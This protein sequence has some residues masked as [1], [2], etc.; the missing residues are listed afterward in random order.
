[1]DLRI[2]LDKKPAK[3]PIVIE[4][5]PGFGLIG[6]IATEY[7]IENLKAELIGTFEFDEMPP[8][9]AIHQGKLVHPMGIFYAKE[10][11]L[12]I[13]HAILNTTGYEWK[14]ANA[15]LEMCD[16]ISVKEMIC[17]E[18]VTSLSQ[19]TETPKT[20]FFTQDEKKKSA[21]ESLGM[22]ALDE[23]IIMGVTGA[24]LIKSQKPITCFFVQ[25]VSNLPDSKS[26]AGII[27]HL[28]KYLS[29]SIDTGPLIKQAD[30]FEKK[31]KKIQ[32]QALLASREQELSKK[33]NYLG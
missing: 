24:L 21:L 23:S 25:T 5:F 17:I 1:L 4:G 29:L 27:E 32:E 33:P 7:L 28:D 8:T 14:V 11:N 31:L 19:N 6:T 2:I 12:I 30:A 10:Q 18:G 22:S 3:N 20:Y 26:A 16:D 15:I 9:L 13:L